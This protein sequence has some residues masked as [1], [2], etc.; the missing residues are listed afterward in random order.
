MKS[1][2]QDWENPTENWLEDIQFYF[3]QEKQL[4]VGNYKQLGLFHYVENA[5]CEKVVKNNA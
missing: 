2:V 5:C 4:K 1:R 3:D